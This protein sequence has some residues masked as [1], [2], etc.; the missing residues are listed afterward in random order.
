MSWFTS[1]KKTRSGLQ[2]S[3]LK[4]GQFVT[5]KD[6]ESQL[7]VGLVLEVLVYQANPTELRVLMNGQVY[8]EV[9]I[10]WSAVKEIKGELQFPL[11]EQLEAI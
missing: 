11:I 3:D 5:F 10:E 2:A 9:F 4:Q 1:S 8:K 6:N 7:R